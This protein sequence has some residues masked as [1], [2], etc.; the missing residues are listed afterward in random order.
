MIFG[1][2]VMAFADEVLTVDTSLNVQNTD[3]DSNDPTT[4]ET[5]L[6]SW[7]WHPIS[8]THEEV[9]GFN[10]IR[11]TYAL[12]P[13]VNPAVIP[14]EHI[15]MF[16]QVFTFAYMVQQPT[17]NDSYMEAR[18]TVTI[19]TSTSMLNDILPNLEREIRFDRDGYAG[20]LSLDIE[21]IRSESA[22]T[23][24]RNANV[25]RRRTYPHLSSQD[26]SLIPNTIVEGGITLHLSNVEWQANSSTT[27]DGLPVASTFTAHATYTTTI[28]QTSTIGYITTAEY[29]GIAT[30][31]VPGKTL[32]TVVFVSTVPVDP[33]PIIIGDASGT[34]QENAGEDMNGNGA[35][36]GSIDTNGA[37]DATGSTRTT[38]EASERRESNG[39][40]LRVL[41]IILCLLIIAGIIIYLI[42][43]FLCNNVSVYSIH[44]PREI[45]KAGKI[46]MD[47]DSPEPEVSLDKVVGGSPSSTGRYLIQVAGRAVPKIVGK[48]IR[49]TMHDME[50]RHLI[51]EGTPH[52][53]V[54]EFE[55]NFSDEDD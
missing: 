55:V 30:R 15:T 2:P 27:I 53:S 45:V 18:Q 19:E 11:K 34:G 48:T 7:V 32:Y 41:G 36:E 49:V 23:S 51:P 21:T 14:V 3:A 28:T 16:G 38:S 9:N 22:G 17:A 25:T 6:D 40:A 50:A 29:V 46:K 1:L 8:V 47:V 35:T 39:S 31:T 44:G 54:Y 43:Q 10:S 42:K 13:D 12:P 24:S 33:A 4:Q 26:N 52:D 5:A 37:V 20:I